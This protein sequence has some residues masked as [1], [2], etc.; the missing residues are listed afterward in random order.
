M[1]ALVAI[2]VL[3]RSC[4]PK[5]PPPEVKVDTVTVVKE[6]NVEIPVKVYVPKEVIKTETKYVEVPAKVDT[7]IILKDYFARHYYRDSARIDTLGYVI[8]EDEITE[9]RIASRKTF[10]HYTIKIPERTITIT[11]EERKAKLFIGPELGTPLY[12][13]AKLDFLTKQDQLY[14]IGAGMG[15]GGLQYKI[16]IGFKIKLK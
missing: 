13:G 3:Q 16:G 1:I 10:G 2:I 5:P 15:A 14:T 9:N 4:G 11:K 7:A 8:I 12:G 6:K